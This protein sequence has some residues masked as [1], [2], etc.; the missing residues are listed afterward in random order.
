M[1]TTEC[2][3]IVAD[4]GTVFPAIPS[5]TEKALEKFDAKGWDV[6]A[7]YSYLEDGRTFL[8][9]ITVNS[10]EINSLVKP[11]MEDIYIG[12]RDASSLTALNEQMNAILER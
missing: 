4:I 2:Q 11:A 10:A 1:G 12:N 7:F 3:D 8:P 6:T 9:P 5:S